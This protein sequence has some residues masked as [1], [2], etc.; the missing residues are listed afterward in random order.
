MGVATFTPFSHLLETFCWVL[1][2]SSSALTLAALGMG[3]A[4]CSGGRGLPTIASIAE[5]EPDVPSTGLMM[6]GASASMKS[7]KTS[8]SKS[9]SERSP[10]IEE[11]FLEIS[12]QFEAQTSAMDELKRSLEQAM[13]KIEDQGQTIKAQGQTIEDQGL[14]IG[15]QGVKIEEQ[16]QTI[17]TQGTNLA[18]MECAKINGENARYCTAYNQ[19][20]VGFVQ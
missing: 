18:Y 4:S 17:E 5:T 14:T 10:T 3:F 6:A 2:P 1:N 20:T 13:T 16:G 7:K 12:T 8:K 9:M 19:P 15:E 11:R